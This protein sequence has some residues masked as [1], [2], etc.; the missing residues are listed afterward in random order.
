MKCNHCHDLV[1]NGILHDS[2]KKMVVN[3]K[4]EI[5]ACKGK[6]VLTNGQVFKERYGF[7]KTMK[8]NMQKH[9]IDPFGSGSIQAY[10]E[11]RKKA[12]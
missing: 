3:N 9:D 2:C 4:G 10:R 11:I 12:K 6:L 8:R 5:V 1:E 7:S